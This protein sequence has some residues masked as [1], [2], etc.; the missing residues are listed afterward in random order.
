MA[1]TMPR[2]LVAT[3]VLVALLAA[4]VGGAT[5][6]IM[7][8]GAN[9]VDGTVTGSDIADSSL[10]GVDIRNGSLS[11]SEFNRTVIASLNLA[12]DTRVPTAMAMRTA[13]LLIPATET[14]VVQFGTPGASSTGPMVVKRD[15]RLILAGTVSAFK[16]GTLWAA[17]GRMDCRLMYR[18][19]AARSP[20]AILTPVSLVLPRSHAVMP[21]TTGTIPLHAM[22]T[23]GPGTYEGL[24]RCRTII[25]GGY[26]A[27]M[28]VYQATVQGQVAPL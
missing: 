13:S 1:I 18:K 2:W 10:T 25:G 20:L 6:A 26:A 16:P 14:T 9:I 8:T 24:V 4:S 21:T 23:V 27:H 22:V 3:F 15:S 7:V 19:A 11:R 28:V 12:N 17:N 5:A